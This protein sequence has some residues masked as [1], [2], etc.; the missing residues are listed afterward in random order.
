MIVYGLSANVA[1]GDLFMAGA[2]PG[3]MLATFYAIYT[4]IRCYINPSLAP[5][6]EEVT[7][8]RGKEMKL[9]KEKKSAVMMCVFLIFCVMG[10]IYAGIASVTD[11]AAV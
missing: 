10:S 8:A 2:V 1:I 4:L 6:A 7:A 3:L 11:A 9:D 5:N